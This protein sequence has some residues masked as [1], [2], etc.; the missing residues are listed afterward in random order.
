MEVSPLHI[1]DAGANITTPRI[2]SVLAPLFVHYEV[3][4][5]LGLCK[6]VHRDLQNDAAKLKAEFRLKKKG[7]KSE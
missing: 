2:A 1:Y 5:S 3:L 7:A 6:Q 4:F